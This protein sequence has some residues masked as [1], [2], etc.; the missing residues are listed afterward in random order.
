MKQV[1]AERVKTGDAVNA[2]GEAL[3]SVPKHFRYMSPEVGRLVD[4]MEKALSAIDE[5]LQG[6]QDGN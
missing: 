1:S 3:A 4:A 5:E 2:V 6:L